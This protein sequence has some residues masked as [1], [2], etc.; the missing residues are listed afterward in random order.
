[1]NELS[2][3]GRNGLVFLRRG[4]VES[5][6]AQGRDPSIVQGDVLELWWIDGSNLNAATI[7]ETDLSIGSVNTALNQPVVAY[8]VKFLP[9]TGT[10]WVAATTDTLFTQV[11]DNDVKSTIWNGD[12]VSG[13]DFEFDPQ[14][15]SIVVSTVA[16][17]QTDQGF[18]QQFVQA[19]NKLVDSF[20]VYDYTLGPQKL[21]SVLEQYWS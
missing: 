1:M 10:A 7:N 20:F 9:E 4:L 12:V 13:V 11:A 18:I 19:A 16:A 5:Q 8:S 2:A 15:K 6:V 17:S 21:P 14:G 3:Y